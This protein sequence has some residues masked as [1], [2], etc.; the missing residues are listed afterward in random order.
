M[1]HSIV[2]ALK[3]A[4][5]LRRWRRAFAQAR[6][7]QP[8]PP[9]EPAAAPGGQPTAW[10]RGPRSA[11][12]I[13]PVIWMYWDAPGLPFFI[14]LCVQR[15]RRLNPHLALRLLRPGDLHQYLDLHP[16][17]QRATVHQRADWI[18]L[19][20]LR[21]HGGIWLDASTL[22]TAPLDWVFDAQAACG[23]E[24]VGFH[25]QQSQA[26]ARYPVVENWFMAAPPGSRFI[27]DWQ[28]AFTHHV[29]EHGA[30]AYLAALRASGRWPQLAQRIP[31]PQY[32]TMH[33]C[34]QD[35][36]QPGF[37]YRLALAG[38]E[39]S[40]FLLHERSGWRRHEL[41]LALLARPAPA[42][43]PALVKLRSMDRKY[44]EAYVRHRLYRPDSLIGQ[45]VDGAEP[46]AGGR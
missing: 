24:F 1:P 45:L 26:D 14:D 4:Y 23:S 2:T 8:A 22:L 3:T 16:A 38:A 32:L 20:L 21:R 10:G 43:P 36:I 33:L 19:E 34:A 39:D 30:G 12:P 6:Q 11:Q 28:H 27:E 17:L 15:I 7:Q 46:P 9:E 35:I 40:A 44:L 25:I 18:R 37:A 29:I 31:M 42:H 41:H 13:P 5:H